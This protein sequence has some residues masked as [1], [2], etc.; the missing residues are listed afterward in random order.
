MQFASSCNGDDN[1]EWFD[2]GE[3]AGNPDWAQDGL[4]MNWDP[5][6]YIQGY[7]EGGYQN[8]QDCRQDQNYHYFAD[9]YSPH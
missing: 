5:C 2:P 1:C 6:L 8:E 9:R 3:D 4:C 7:N